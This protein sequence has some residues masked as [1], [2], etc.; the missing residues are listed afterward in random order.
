MTVH[1]TEDKTIVVTTAVIP[2][3][4]VDGMVTHKVMQKLQNEDGK[5]VNRAFLAVV[6]I[7]IAEAV[8]KEAVLQMVAE[9]VVEV[10]PA[11]KEVIPAAVE[12][13]ITMTTEVTVK[14]DGSVIPKDTQKQ[15]NAAG[16]TEAIRT[17]AV[18]IVVIAAVAMDVMIVTT[19]MIT[20]VV[21][22]VV[23]DMMKM[24]TMAAAKVVAGLVIPKGMLKQQSAAGKIAATINSESKSPGSRAICFLRT[25]VISKPRSLRCLFRDL[26]IRHL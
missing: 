13:I 14:E 25:V 24:M 17:V 11:A 22:A 19:T 9:A 20:I 3:M 18:P 21:I 6:V 15:Q 26:R 7:A 10:T 4:D 5:T 23:A 2:A 1:Q 8:H 12:T 16:K